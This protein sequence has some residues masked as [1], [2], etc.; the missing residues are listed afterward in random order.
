MESMSIKIV[1]VG[2]NR[3]WFPNKKE[4]MLAGREYEVPHTQYWLRRL[5]DGSVKVSCP[6]AAEKKVK[7]SKKENSQEKSSEVK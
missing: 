7:V 2:E 5:A 6:P 1:L 3:V 4:L